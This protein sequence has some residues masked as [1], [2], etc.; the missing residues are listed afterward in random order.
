MPST[1]RRH[2]HMLGGIHG[3][4]H[5]A[6]GAEHIRRSVARLRASTSQAKTYAS[7]HMT[8]ELVDTAILFQQ[9]RGQVEDLKGAI[10][11]LLG[12]LNTADTASATELDATAKRSVELDDDLEAKLDESYPDSGQSRSTPPTGL[13]TPNMCVALPENALVAPATSAPT[14]L[15]TTILTTNWLSPSTLIDQ[16]IGY[17]AGLA[18]MER[19]LTLV[20]K[21]F[22]GNWDKLY[23]CGD[24]VSNLARYFE[25]QAQGRRTDMAAV[26][27]TWDGEAAASAE[28]FFATQ[29]DVLDTAA[30]YLKDTAPRVRRRRARYE[31]VRESRERI[32][33]DRSRCFAHRL[34]LL[35]GRSRDILDHRRRHR[36]RRLR[37]GCRG[38]RDICARRTFQRLPR[39]FHDPGRAHIPDRR[40]GVMVHQRFNPSRR[41]G[42]RQRPGVTDDR[43]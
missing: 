23:E 11:S 42:V 6:I 34:G 24:A 5:L 8:L 1:A 9:A 21:R 36:R 15:A 2:R 22:G 28:T 3:V 13:G 25:L 33:L 30:Q 10:A 29:A 20:G 37:H 41:F 18:G 4:F 12:V 7:D 35:R 16:A 17:V 19:P 32:L 27:Q 43:S 40:C 39:P 38:R 26:R 14:D 31:V